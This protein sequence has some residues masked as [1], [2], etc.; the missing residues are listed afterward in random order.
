MKKTVNKNKKLKKKKFA[1]GIFLM[2]FIVQSILALGGTAFYFYRSGLSKIKDIETYNKNYSITLAEAFTDV[3]ELSYGKK[4]YSR[5]KRL[6]RKKIQENTIDEAFFVLKNGKLIVHSNKNIEKSLRGNIANDEFAYNIDLILWPVKRKSKKVMFTPYNIMGKSVPFN[7]EERRLIKK[8][9]Y[10][11]INTLGWLVTRAVYYKGSPV[12]TVNF[13]IY[14]E[15]IHMF[16]KDHINMAKQYF[17]YAI[18]GAF[19]LSF[20]ISLI[21][22]LRYRSIQKSTLRA[23]GDTGFMTEEIM[24]P[25]KEKK[26]KKKKY[27]SDDVITIELSDSRASY[28]APSPEEYYHDDY[29]PPTNHVNRPSRQPAT[30]DEVS[31]QNMGRE[32]KDAIPVTRKR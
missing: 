20:F 3:A 17:I 29:R 7:R 26:K 14:N 16:L 12:G 15:R 28:R 5:L 30:F 22:L 8:Y 27:Y 21:V 31:L 6:F 24:G 9:Y 18:A 1:M 11:D 25:E 32:I 23:A 2:L 19:S 4:N 10:K 13:L